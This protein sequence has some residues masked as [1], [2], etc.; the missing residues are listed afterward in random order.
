MTSMRIARAGLFLGLVLL[1]GCH[2][3][4][5]PL[6][7]RLDTTSPEPQTPQDSSYVPQDSTGVPPDSTAVPQDSSYVAGDVI[8]GFR[9]DV[10]EEQANAMFASYGLGWESH[11]SRLF[12]YWVEVMSG[13]PAAYVAEL[14]RS[15]IVLWAKRR[16]NPHGT[17]GANYIIVMFSTRATDESA[18]ALIDSFPGLRVTSTLS[19]PRWGVANVPP[20]TE[21]Y[22]I[23]VLEKEPIVTYASLNRILG[24]Y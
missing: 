4:T 15:P 5:G 1:A 11:F 19:G 20:G 12:A 7:M 9:E 3:T 14:N 18:Q 13:D 24:L 21:Q 8:V 6:G 22:W 2:F 16:G 17:P 10:T 23:E